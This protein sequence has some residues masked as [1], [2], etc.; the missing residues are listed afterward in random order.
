[1]TSPA[2]QHSFPRHEADQPA[3][4]TAP[5]AMRLVA[6]RGLEAMAAINSGSFEQEWTALANACSWSTVFQRPDFIRAWLRTYADRFEPIV[7]E[8]RDTSGTLVGLLLLAHDQH[9]GSIAHMGTHHAE[10]QTWLALDAD[11]GTFIVLALRWIDDA[12]L[13]SSLRFHFLAPGTP[14]D[15]VRSYEGLLSPRCF[16]SSHRRGMLDL[17]PA[18]IHGSLHKRANRSKLRRIEREGPVQLLEITDAAALEPW[19]PAIMSYCDVRQGALHGVMPFRDDPRK[20]DFY[21][22]LLDVPELMHAALLVSGDELLAA[23]IGARNG[24][25]VL[26]GLIAHAPQ[27]GLNSPGKLLLLRLFERLAERGLRLFDLTPGGAYKERFASRFDEVL[28]LEI[29]LSPSAA[30]A[31]AVERAGREVG[32]RL[33]GRRTPATQTR[34]T[35]SVRDVECTAL[36][37]G[38]LD[39]ALLDHCKE[40]VEQSKRGGW[41]VN[42][43]NAAALL[44]A[45]GPNTDR[46]SL[47]RFLAESTPRLEHGAAVSTVSRD[48]HLHLCAWLEPD[49][50]PAD[51]ADLPTNPDARIDGDQ[52]TVALQISVVVHHRITPDQASMAAVAAVLLEGR[53]RFPDS[54]AIRLLAPAVCH[55]QICLAFGFQNLC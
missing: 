27:H 43:N 26:L 25:S 13:C 2:L 45:G 53:R 36:R 17:Q 31:R 34:V 42:V 16:V 29:C 39:N 35:R 41:S 19:L 40:V 23:H 21:R 55:P 33:L 20:A 3:P 47:L 38:H 37:Q 4:A 51:G 14:T 22:A 32:R 24:D 9:N 7:L 1:M 49:R 48:G 46:S 50:R 6:K 30:T 5:H 18:D 54:V 28:T 52:E 12:R 10:Y 8:A 44:E 15:W 11:A